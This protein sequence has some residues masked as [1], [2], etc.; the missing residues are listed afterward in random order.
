MDA[1]KYPLIGTKPGGT[2]P[3]IAGTRIR[4]AFLAEIFKDIGEGPHA[5]KEVMRVY[6]HLSREQIEQAIQYWHDNEAEI[7]AEIREDEEAFRESQAAQQG[8]LPK[9]PSKR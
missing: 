2:S 8:F 9:T 4:V 1:K 3:A 7:E 5:I 6:D